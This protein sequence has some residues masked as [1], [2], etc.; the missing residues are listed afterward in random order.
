MN[1]EIITPP[2]IVECGGKK[3]WNT[4]GLFLPEDLDEEPKQTKQLT[5]EERIVAELAGEGK[6]VRQKK[7]IYIVR[8]T[9]FLDKAREAVKRINPKHVAYAAAAGLAGII[10]MPAMAHADNSL[11]T[12]A[13]VMPDLHADAR[14]G[15]THDG[16]EAAVE[17][18]TDDDYDNH[19]TILGIRTPDLAG[20]QLRQT[21]ILEYGAGRD[22]T[23]G[24]NTNLFYTITPVKLRLGIGAGAHFPE[25]DWITHGNISYLGEIVRVSADVLHHADGEYPADGRGFARMLLPNGFYLSAGKAEG[26]NI[27]NAIGYVGGEGSFNAI[28]RNWFNYDNLSSKHDL[29]LMWNS[30]KGK[31]FY[32][33]QTNFFTSPDGV[34]DML[35][36]NY[37]P[38][39]GWAPLLDM[40]GEYCMQIQASQDSNGVGGMAMFAYNPNNAGNF[41]EIGGRHRHNFEGD[42]EATVMLNAGTDLGPLVVMAGTTADVRDGNLAA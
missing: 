34:W 21:G 3:Y 1:Q 7:G 25:T 30:T 4:D 17:Q 24:F 29:M 11:T 39:I 20:F 2:H 18:V 33:F 28:M 35:Q 36:G 12:E 10:A 32:D 23:E 5:G 8:D 41:L 14:V 9:G 27:F 37:D 38:T 16:L 13:M 19:S 42:D 22:T 31:G 40:L 26:P 6:I 15:V